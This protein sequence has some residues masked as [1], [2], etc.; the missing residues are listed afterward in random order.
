MYLYSEMPKLIETVSQSGY[1]EPDTLHQ[2]APAS[3]TGTARLPPDPQEQPDH[4]QAVLG[5]K[6]IEEEESGMPVH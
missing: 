6:L 1:L 4:L 5:G 2:S 3:Q